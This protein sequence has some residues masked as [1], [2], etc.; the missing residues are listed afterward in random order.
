MKKINLNCVYGAF[1]PG[2]NEVES[3]IAEQLVAAGY[4]TYDEGSLGVATV[5]K[6][7]HDSIVAER[8]ALIVERD[9]ALAELGMAQAELEA[10]KDGKNSPA[11]K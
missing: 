4:A 1:A 3:E 5:S 8:D 11:K 6:D 2:L 7:V 10:A 9:N